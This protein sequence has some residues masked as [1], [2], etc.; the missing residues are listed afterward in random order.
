[1][2]FE[3][4]LRPPVALPLPVH[5]A[6]AERVPGVGAEADSARLVAEREPPALDEQV[7]LEIFPV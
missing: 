5:D 1:V 7:L 4:P 6:E 2:V 3:G